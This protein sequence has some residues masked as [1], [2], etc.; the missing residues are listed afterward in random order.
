MRLVYYVAIGASVALLQG[1]GNSSKASDSKNEDSTRKNEQVIEPVNVAED[2]HANDG[3]FSRMR[4]EHMEAPV[5]SQNVEPEQAKGS[6]ANENA[7]PEFPKKAVTQH[8]VS[9]V[10][11]KKNER[12]EHKGS[13]PLIQ[14][15]MIDSLFYWLD[16]LPEVR[17]IYRTWNWGSLEF[18]EVALNLYNPVARLAG[19]IRQKVKEAKPR[20]MEAYLAVLKKKKEL[21]EHKYPDLRVQLEK[22]HDEVINMLSNTIEQGGLFGPDGYHGSSPEVEA[23]FATSQKMGISEDLMIMWQDTWK[24]I[25]VESNRV[26]HEDLRALFEVAIKETRVSEK[27]L[28]AKFLR[29]VEVQR[30][31]PLVV[32][33][34]EQGLGKFLKHSSELI[35]S[36]M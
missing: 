26:G 10:K 12:R 21:V 5:E 1:C 16:S 33:S 30:D 20:L 3:F 31:I 17:D 35:N 24:E 18:A 6:I 13:I 29:N 34:I 32:D 27:Y 2:P 4:E 15:D 25:W 19:S 14:N 8:K 36:T 9:F 23:L 22:A 7:V 11:G 28:L